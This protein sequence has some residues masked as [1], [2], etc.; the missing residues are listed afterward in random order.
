MFPVSRRNFIRRVAAVGAG[1]MVVKLGSSLMSGMRGREWDLLLKPGSALAA[2]STGS[3]TPKYAYVV[4]VGTCIGCRKCVGACKE[5]NGTPEGI[6]WMDLL[7]P[8]DADYKYLPRPCMHCDNPPCTKVCPV[9]ARYKRP[10][11]FVLTDFKRCIGCRYCQVACPYGVNYF[12]WKNPRSSQA[13]SSSP[14][15]LAEY[16]DN[17][18]RLT[19]GGGHYTGVIEKC[20]WCIHRIEKGKPVPA[21]VEICPVKALHFGDL[22]DPNSEVSQII[23]KNKYFRLLEELG[24]EPRVFYTGGYPPKLNRKTE[25]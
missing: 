11:G 6:F 12:N 4:D 9:N 2:T 24:T 22:N 19:A 16:R 25:K 10:E 13:P 8:S 18:G 15:S 14:S 23:S 5:E 20:T 3:P 1:L 17:D 7:Y 21:C